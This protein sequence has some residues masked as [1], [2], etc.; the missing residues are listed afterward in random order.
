M[1]VDEMDFAEGIASCLRARTASFDTSL[2]KQQFSKFSRQ[3][4]LRLH[5]LPKLAASPNVTVVTGA[6]VISIDA[7]HTG[8]KVETVQIA[9]YAG[10]KAKLSASSYILC[11]GAIENARLLLASRSRRTEGIGNEYDLVGRFFQDHPGCDV[12]TIR[13]L[14]PDALQDLFNIYYRSGVRYKPRFAPTRELQTR[15]RILNI[16][17]VLLFE[18][19]PDSAFAGIRDTVRAARM[20]HLS[21]PS[22]RQWKNGLSEFWGIGKSIKSRYLN[23]RHYNPNAEIH[24]AFTAEQEPD[25]ESRVMLSA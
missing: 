5:Y 12:G 18:Q 1:F 19:R 25:P 22:I 11:C 7:D 4:D 21:L 17:G 16:S 24:L 2:I 14:D 13:S 9:S 20:G 10:Q 6:N 23:R 8:R 15:L 3:P